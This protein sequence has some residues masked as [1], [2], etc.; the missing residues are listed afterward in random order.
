VTRA[1][2]GIRELGKTAGGHWE[3][4]THFVSEG[5]QVMSTWSWLAFMRH[6]EERQRSFGKKLPKP[7]LKPDYETQAHRFAEDLA[8]RVLARPQTATA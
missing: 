2:A 6:A 7:N 1:I 3:G 5:N 8:D 4:Q